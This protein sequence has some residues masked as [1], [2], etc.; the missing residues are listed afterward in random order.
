MRSV[1]AGRR[2][3]RRAGRLGQFDL[4]RLA[5]GRE[6]AAPGAAQAA[7]EGGEAAVTT[8]TATPMSTIVEPGG[9]SFAAEA[10]TPVPAMRKPAPIAVNM[11]VLN[12]RVNCWTVTTGITRRALTRSRPTARIETETVTAVVIR[13]S[14]LSA[15]TGRPET[16]AYC[17]SAQIAVSQGRSTS[18]RIGDDRAA[19]GD[20]P[21]LVPAGGQER[22]EQV[23][24]EVGHA[25]VGGDAG[26]VDAAGD[27]AVEHHGEGHV[28]GG[29]GVA[30]EDAP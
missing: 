7:D 22:A 27:A 10:S 29:L 1:A 21:D 25:F 3:G 19:D 12:E 14:R 17:S 13:S 20:G 16:R 26:E 4:E 9:T 28:A 6:V 18:M 8:K 23:L 2:S 11:V 5:F 15:E 24:L 30:A